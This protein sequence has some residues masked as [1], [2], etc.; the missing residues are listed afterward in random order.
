MGLDQWFSA[1][2]G[3]WPPSKDPQ[4]MWPSALQ[5]GFAISRESR[6]FCSKQIYYK[7]GQRE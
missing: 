7:N 3:L 6:D 5:K 4:Q 1:F 2:H